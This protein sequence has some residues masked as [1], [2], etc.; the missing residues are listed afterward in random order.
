MKTAKKI[1]LSDYSAFGSEMRARTSGT[2]YR[3]GFNSKEKDDEVFNLPST[4]YDFGSRMYDSR[5]GRW[6]S[7]DPYAS[8]YSPYSPYCFALN[9]PIQAIDRDG[10]LVIYANGLRFGASFK[11]G[12]YRLFV[13]EARK[14]GDSPLAE[15]GEEVYSRY[16]Q[17]NGSEKE[18]ND[19]WGQIREQF[20]NYFH[21]DNNAYVDGTNKWWSTAKQ[22]SEEGELAALT[23][24]KKI[25]SGE[26]VLKPGETIK[27]VAHSQGGAYAAGLAKKLIAMGY[28]VQEIHYIA[29][30][31]PGGIEHP[32]GLP[33]YQYSRKTDAIV[34]KGFIPTFISH[35]SFALIKS[36]NVKAAIIPNI[37][38][39]FGSG[40]YRGHD[41]GTYKDYLPGGNKNDSGDGNNPSPPD[42]ESPE[43]GDY[44]GSGPGGAG[45]PNTGGSG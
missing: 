41:V 7:T 37:N 3:Y 17:I 24:D 42:A 22:R 33:G 9:S 13:P 12:I 11:R 31:Q 23:L 2:Q 5:L 30:A 35:S 18:S 14:L 40:G 36:D 44:P 4:S 32:A 16:F 10:E 29:P 1:P 20:N 28:P 26:V 45:I 25:K 39:F 15:D 43:G 21:D 38:K 27:I 34:S 19:Y 6:N 8:L